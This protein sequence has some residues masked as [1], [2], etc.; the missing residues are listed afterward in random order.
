MSAMPIPADPGAA[1]LAAAVPAA[2]PVSPTS[3]YAGVGTATLTAPDGTQVPY[4]LR[5]F[6]PPPERFTVVGEHRVAPGERLDII[7]AR[8][9]GDPTQ[10]WRLCDA[11]LAMRPAELETPERVLRLTLPGE[12]GG[13]ADG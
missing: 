7:T 2:P 1:A 9:L 6:I 5:R 12:I 8:H 10:F 3:R 4:L 11:N 13:G